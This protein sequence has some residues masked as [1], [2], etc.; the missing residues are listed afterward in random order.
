MTPPPRG[1]S[2]IWTSGRTAL[3]LAL[4]TLPADSQFMC[5]LPEGKDRVCPIIV[6][7]RPRTGLCRIEAPDEPL[8]ERGNII[9]K[10]PP[11]L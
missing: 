11:Y 2:E 10:V 3:A 9:S 7:T 5:Q 1:P 8:N 4:V 6:S